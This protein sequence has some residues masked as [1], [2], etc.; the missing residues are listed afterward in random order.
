MV[1]VLLLMPGTLFIHWIICWVLICKSTYCSNLSGSNRAFCRC[2]LEWTGFFIHCAF[3]LIDH[4]AT[5][6]SCHSA[7]RACPELQ[8]P[9]I[10]CKGK[11]FHLGR[12]SPAGQVRGPEKVFFP[13]HHLFLLTVPPL[14]EGLSSFMSV[15]SATSPSASRRMK[16]V[17]GMMW[18]WK[19]WD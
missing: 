1:S 6:L 15:D 14:L 2:K 10:K 5:S 9:L 3:S 16:G 12:R 18:R 13:V 19:V 8:N 4:S 11:P 7:R 17:G